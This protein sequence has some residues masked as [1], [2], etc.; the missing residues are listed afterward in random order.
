MWK[1]IAVLHLSE[2]EVK[3]VPVRSKKE[4]KKKS[5]AS[6]EERGKLKFKDL[7]EH[8]HQGRQEFLYLKK[9]K[10]MLQ[11]SDENRKAKEHINAFFTC[12]F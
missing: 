7:A 6:E 10:M 3:P 1:K 4:K 9:K 2:G 11:S 5:P 8:D 12:D